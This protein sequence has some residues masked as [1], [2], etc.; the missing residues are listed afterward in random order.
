MAESTIVKLFNFLFFNKF[1]RNSFFVIFDCFYK[2]IDAVLELKNVKNTHSIWKPMKWKMNVLY[3]PGNIIYLTF[4]FICFIIFAHHNYKYST[5]PVN[6]LPSQKLVPAEFSDQADIFFGFI[7]FIGTCCGANLL[8]HNMKN[9]NEHFRMY[10]ILHSNGNLKKMLQ[11]KQVIK[12]QTAIKIFQLH[13][14]AKKI[15]QFIYVLIHIECQPFYY[16]NV[17]N[18]WQNSYIDYFTAVWIGISVPFL[19]L[20]KC[21][22]INTI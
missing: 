15:I 12:H 13:K 7:I 17:I 10:A 2:D 11:N 5:I 8:F 1:F 22:I 19:T 21:M 4:Y 6:V 16:F 9:Y 3:L 20:S 14:K 18:N